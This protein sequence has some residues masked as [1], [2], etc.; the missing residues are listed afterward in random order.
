MSSCFLRQ[1]GD[2]LLMMVNLCK[3]CL[4]IDCFLYVEMEIVIYRIQT[5]WFWKRITMI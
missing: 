5:C 4:E 3:A 2:G 1:P